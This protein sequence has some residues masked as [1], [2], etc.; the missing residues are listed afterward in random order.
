M[1]GGLLIDG[2]VIK[3]LHLFVLF[4]KQVIKVM[5]AVCQLL[6]V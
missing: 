1:S 2:M 5:T 6:W 3:G 4:Q